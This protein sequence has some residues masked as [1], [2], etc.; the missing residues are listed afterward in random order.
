LTTQNADAPTRSECWRVGIAVTTMASAL[1]SSLLGGVRRRLLSSSAPAA[2]ASGAAGGGFAAPVFVTEAASGR[3][4]SPWHDL[5][6]RP[7]GAPAGV[8]NFLCEIPLAA[9]PPKLELDPSRPH[10]AIVQDKNKDGSPRRYRLDTCV[11]AARA[12]ARTRARACARAVES[13]AQIPHPPSL[14]R[15]PFRRLRRRL[16]HYGCLPRTYEDPAHKDRWTGL[17]GDGDPADV[18]DIAVGRAPAPRPGAA[19]RVKVLGAL[20]MIDGGE[21]DWKVLA[22]RADDPLAAQVD[23]VA[24]ALRTPAAVLRLADA[25]REWFRLYKVPEGKGENSFAFEGRWLG[26]DTALEVIADT[27]AQYLRLLAAPR[28]APGTKGAPW[29]PPPGRAPP[30][31]DF[32]QGDAARGA[33]LLTGVT[34][35]APLK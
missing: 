24:D 3:V 26:R 20:A 28:A 7:A 21:T 14:R 25:V 18:C 35:Q 12:R 22:V 32:L 29:L 15:P 10:N 30:P 5:P 16:I 13:S 19:Y 33:E 11:V 1:R 2:A 34:T 17:L 31:D 27:H 8:V 4:L 6:L 9:Q 23:D